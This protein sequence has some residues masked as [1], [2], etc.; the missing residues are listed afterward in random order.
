MKCHE[1]QGYEI[2]DIRGGISVTMPADIYQNSQSKQE[3]N[4]YFMHLI[5]LLVG[6]GGLTK[7][8]QLSNNHLNIQKNINADLRQHQEELFAT[9]EELKATTEAVELQNA[10]INKQNEELKTINEQL[11]ESN[12]AVEESEARLK[13]INDLAPIGLLVFDKK[14][15]NID[16]VKDVR[17]FLYYIQQ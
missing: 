10:E 12:R 16:S 13:A 3:R 2:G 14:G 17:L 8:R 7:H 6:I 5:I 11:N 9:N 1:K 4:V 15:K